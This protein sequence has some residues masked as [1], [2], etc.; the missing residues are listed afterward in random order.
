[1]RGYS[2]SAHPGPAQAVA[3]DNDF[4]AQFTANA[5]PFSALMRSGNNRCNMRRNDGVI[6]LYSG[7]TRGYYDRPHTDTGS[8]R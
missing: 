1:M 7:D 3:A 8:Y 2:Y 5:Y 4:H 6:G